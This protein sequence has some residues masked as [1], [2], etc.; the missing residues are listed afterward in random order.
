MKFDAH[1][2]RTQYWVSLII[3]SLVVPLVVAMLIAI[4]QEIGLLLATLL[5]C[6]L[7]WFQFA[8]QK[9]RLNDAGWCGWW[10]LVPIVNFI[11]PGFFATKDDDNPYKNG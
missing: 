3:A 11:V 6:A 4:H 7:I 1:V 9:A 8:L 2:T 5:T 10:M